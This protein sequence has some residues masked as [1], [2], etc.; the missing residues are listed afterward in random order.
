MFFYLT[1][2]IVSFCS[3][4]ANETVSGID[5]YIEKTLA[6]FE[7]PGAAVGVIVNGEVIL[8]KGYGT[9]R[10]GYKQPVTE[11]TLFSIGSCTKA[12]TA[13][14][15]AQLVEEGKLDW[16][17]PV[18]THLPEFAC[19][20][21]SLTIRDLLA[22][23]T[24]YHRMD[25]TWA[26]KDISKNDV[27]DI[28]RHAEPAYEARTRFTYN[29]YMYTIAGLVIERLLGISW[30]EALSSRIFIP[31]EMTDSCTT[32]CT[33]SCSLGHAFM[34]NEVQSVPYSNLSG[35]TPAGGIYSSLSDMIKWAKGH[36]MQLLP[37]TV[38][39]L[40]TISQPAPDFDVMVDGY[41]LGWLIGSYQGHTLVG[42]SG[43]TQ[44]FIAD[45][46]MVPEK[47]ITIIILTNSSTDGLHAINCIRNNLLDRLLRLEP[48]DWIASLEPVNKAAKQMLKSALDQLHSLPAAL[49]SKEYIGQYE[50]P[51]YG[52]VEITEEAGSLYFIY[53][54][55]K[56]KLF[57]KSPNVLTC[58]IP[59]LR[60]Y[61]IP[62][63]LDMTFHEKGSKLEIPFEG[64]RNCPPTML[65]KV[66]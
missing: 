8:E 50:D 12:F 54:N 59:A 23:R 19:V 36:E 22:H 25:P 7:V 66:K 27:I 65:Q 24:G 38:N 30:E 33:H 55:V 2:F 18:V 29:N 31:L 61:G 60:I 26:L 32:S 62:I 17:D 14:L 16:D 13:H 9:C 44:G 48:I 20:S 41:G 4:F 39:E 21:S 53:G 6:T 34:Y 52:L 15:M 40:Y 56:S 45:F 3:L 28:L 10:V 47:N 43:L 63:S 51:S 11:K 58:D 37:T 5:Q 1:I 49:P 35:I 46:Y 57:I 42:H 64:F